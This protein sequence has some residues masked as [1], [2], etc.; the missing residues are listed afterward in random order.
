MV[1]TSLATSKISLLHFAYM[2][3]MYLAKTTGTDFVTCKVDQ[4]SI[5]FMIY[6]SSH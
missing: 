1:T 3:N 2:E 4:L 6:L 5:I